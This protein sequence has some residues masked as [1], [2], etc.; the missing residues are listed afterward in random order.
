MNDLRY[1]F[2]QL[3]RQPGFTIMAVIALGLGIGAN[4]VLFSAIN[5]LFLRPLTYPKPEQLVRVWGSFP[6]R[7]LDQAN[8]S[9]PRYS[10]WRDQ[11]QCFSK[12]A[13]QSFTGFTLTGRGDPENL[14]GIRVTSDFL[15]TLGIEPL[16]GRTFTADDDRPGGPNVAILSHTLWQK[17]FGADRNILDQPIVLS[18][19]PYTVIGV[20]PETLKFPFARNQVWLPRVFENEGLPPDI[21]QKGT[22]YLT[23]LGRLK[24]GVSREQADEQLHV[25]DRRYAA[26]N[27]EKVDSK[28]GMSTVSFQEDL[29]GRQRP[30]LL[31]LFA[32]VGCVLL[33]A[34]ANV[35]NL[36]LARFIARRKEIAVR[37][38]LGATRARIISQF[39]TESVLISGIAGVLGILL[40]IWGLDL[41]KKV[42]ENFIPRIL[43]VSLD[44][45]VL[46]FAVGVSLL[47]GI[48]LGLIPALHASRNDPIDSLKDSS[49]G[50]TGRQAGRLRACLLVAEVAL[51]LVL[52]VGAVLLVDSF[53]RLQN[54]DPGFRSENITTFFVGLPPGSYPNEEKQASFYE[55]ALE[56]L[57]SVPGVT[58]VAA[59]STLP[60]SDGGNTRSPAAVEGRP[61]PPVSDR[62]ITVRSTISP[63]FFEAL[64][65]PIK[66]GRDFTWRDRKGSPDV[67]I[68]N[69]TMARKLFPGEDPIGHRLITGIQSI[70]REIVGVTGDVRSENLSLPPAAEM[71]Y[72]TAQLDGAFLSVIVRSSRPA[73]SLRPELIAAIHS[74]DPG[75]P[76]DQV[77][78]YSEVLAQA[79]ADRRLSMYLLGGFAA[80]ALALAGMGIYSVIAYG[81]AQRTNEFGIRFALGAVARDVIG[82]V[83]KEGLRLAVIGL[84]I[85]L[86]LSF[87]LTWLMQRLLFEVS[88][89]DPLLY[90]G[91]SLFICGIAALACF[92]PALRATRINPMEALRTE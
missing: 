66:Q 45:H 9:W 44:W 39:L 15:P 51:S 11:Q 13:A 10:A 71:Y 79:Y 19:T 46:S 82:L 50:T 61:V 62:T 29:V 67:V 31:T 90:S 41:L 32:A 23:T 54:V 58:H 47:T 87:A 60:A 5:T 17:R 38:A 16:F 43:E 4:T 24:P 14:Q 48:V 64:G 30:M 42:A 83:M 2:R 12:F 75:L 65:I 6:E 77:Q 57:K 3:L 28:A 25:I 27:S 1:A 35:A 91:V 53:R 74:L 20:M 33:V 89:R 81:V 34:C 70:P 69:E 92:V 85:G 73:S 56:K 86:A 68:I 18:G 26:A 21:I 59:G 49:R 80:L 76:I 72:P 40:A 63:G 84:A 8:V 37:T 55:S 7:G 36:L 22:G 52:L 88:P 78:P